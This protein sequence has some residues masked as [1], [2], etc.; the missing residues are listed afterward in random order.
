M[1]RPAGRRAGDVEGDAEYV[2]DHGLSQHR[3]GRPH[4]DW[5]ARLQDCQPFAEHRHEV[6]VVKR[7]H[8]GQRQAGDGAEDV[9]LVA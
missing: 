1:S 9:D 8:R 5:A 4:V 3:I 7:H 2:G 6:E